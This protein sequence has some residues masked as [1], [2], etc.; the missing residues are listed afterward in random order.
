MK[1][2]YTEI[3]FMPKVKLEMAFLS[4]LLLMS[5][6]MLCAAPPLLSAKELN[7]P[8][9]RI[10]RVCCAFGSDLHLVGI[11]FMKINHIVAI[12]R[13]GEHNYMGDSMEGNGLIYTKN[14]GF[15]DIGHLRDVADWTAYLYSFILINRDKGEV[16]QHLAYE[17]GKKNLMIK[18]NDELD[19][20]E[21]LF[22]A[23]KIAYDL[24]L[25]HELST[26]FGAS[27][28]PMVPERYSSF[29]VEDVYSNLLGVLIG[30]DALKS[31]LPYNAAMTKLLLT[32]LDSLDAVR[33][34]EDT[35]AALEAVRD[36]W[37]TNAKRLPSRKVLL[38]RDTEVFSLVHPWIVPDSISS[39]TKPLILE[40]PKTTPN[41]KSLTDYYRLSIDLNH[42]FPVREIF[43]E[44]E[45]RLI[46]QDDFGILL[47]W[48]ANDLES[49]D[50]IFY[51]KIKSNQSEGDN[52][53][54]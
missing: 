30:I 3:I 15:I 36:K 19:S 47:N 32:T 8:P 44:R 2:D 12:D 51:S 23:G 35:Y 10:I 49:Q 22:L 11:P 20:M 42:K 29:S 13:L 41:G 9:P 53:N 45:N 18:I 28:V 50:Y 27:T 17:G 1:K 21:C 33:M 14:G 38:E 34:E 4:F 54:L 16:E 5:M 39:K 7:S 31:D 37:W 40:V 25:W 6:T 46:T 26:W 43:P 24:S 52:N 48:V